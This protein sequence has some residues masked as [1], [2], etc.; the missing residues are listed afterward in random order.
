MRTSIREQWLKLATTAAIQRTKDMSFEEQNSFWLQHNL[1]FKPFSKLQ[2][3]IYFVTGSHQDQQIRW[4]I[5][6]DCDSIN[7]VEDDGHND[8]ICCDCG[9]VQSYC[10]IFIYGEITNGYQYNTR[11]CYTRKDHLECILI[12]FQCGR[13]RDMEQILYDIQSRFSKLG[14]ETSFKNVQSSLRKLGYCQHYLHIPSI[15]YHLDPEHFKPWKPCSNTIEKTIWI[16]HQYEEHFESF[17]IEHSTGRKNSLNYHYILFKI[18]Q[19]IGEQDIPFRFLSMPK[20][21]RTL[22]EH[23]YIW[24]NICP[25]LKLDFRVNTYSVP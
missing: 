15:L 25:K 14:L 3:I 19:L 13:I 2:D 10:P 22:L 11:K 12:E 1:I 18:L 17:K 8:V 23:E 21:K 7:L 9:M 6:N 5:C 4:D 24:N 16:F 20:G